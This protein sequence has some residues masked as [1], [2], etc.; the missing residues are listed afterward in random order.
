M[1]SYRR[2]STWRLCLIISKNTKRFFA[3]N[4]REISISEENE[5]IVRESLVTR[6]CA[7]MS[8][9]EALRFAKF[10]EDKDAERKFA[11]FPLRIF[12]LVLETYEI[13][14]VPTSTETPETLVFNAFALSN[15]HY[16]QMQRS[17]IA[18]FRVY[19]YNKYFCV[20]VNVIVSSRKV[21]L[22]FFFCAIFSYRKTY[23]AKRA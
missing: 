23:S 2:A 11:K 8:R 3:W 10:D 15:V 14:Y 21:I 5:I 18:I 20:R 16:P 6:D 1:L 13:R 7:S 12:P 4:E 19:K 17:D 22:F 9:E